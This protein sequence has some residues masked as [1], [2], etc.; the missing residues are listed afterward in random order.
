[1][2]TVSKQ[3]K[4]ISLINYVTFVGMIIAYF[5]NKDLKSEYA[6]YHIKIMF[7]LVV[8]LFVSQV[9]HAYINIILGD[10][11]W[12][13][14]FVLWVYAIICAIQIKKPVIPYLSENFQK[15]FTFLD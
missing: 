6:T 13:I 14:S 8:I 10:I 1:M 5:M 4:N 2:E 12:L 7:G 15:W 9:S 3:E 11:L